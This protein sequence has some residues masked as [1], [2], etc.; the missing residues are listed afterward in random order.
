MILGL[1]LPAVVFVSGVAWAAHI[2]VDRGV[3]YG[4]RTREGFQRTPTCR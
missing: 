2:A 4:F 1:W 3:G